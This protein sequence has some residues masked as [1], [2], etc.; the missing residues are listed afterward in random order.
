[1]FH[2]MHDKCCHAIGTVL[3]IFL[4]HSGL[5][6]KEFQ[7]EL[8]NPGADV[9]HGIHLRIQQQK[10]NDIHANT[11]IKRYHLDLW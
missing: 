3:F 1:M 8:V 9:P 4:F 2:N 7:A 6:E 10:N 11:N 5:H